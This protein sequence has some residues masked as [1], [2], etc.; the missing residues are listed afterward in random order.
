MHVIAQ[1]QNNWTD[2]SDMSYS[3]FLHK[4]VPF[5]DNINIAAYLDLLAAD[6]DVTVYSSSLNVF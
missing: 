3:I 6:E 2:F 5:G 1:S 4:I